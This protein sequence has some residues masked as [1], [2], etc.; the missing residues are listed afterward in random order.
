M[1]LAHLVGAGGLVSAVVVA[2]ILVGLRRLRLSVDASV[3]LVD[4]R[5]VVAKGDGLHRLVDAA[6]HTLAHFRARLGFPGRGGATTAAAAAAAGRLGGHLI[7]GAKCCKCY[8]S[9]VDIYM[10]FYPVCFLQ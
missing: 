5:D 7:G 6:A 1:Y 2:E 9:L 3:R 8:E 10:V 4:R